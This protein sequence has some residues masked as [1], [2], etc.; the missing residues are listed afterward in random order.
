MDWIGLPLAFL[1]RVYRPLLM[2]ELLLRPLRN[3][4]KMVNASVMKDSVAA[5][6]VASLVEGKPLP[7]EEK[8]IEKHA[9]EASR[10]LFPPPTEEALFLLL[11]TPHS[12]NGGG[13]FP[14]KTSLSA[15]LSGRRER[16]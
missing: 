11:S 4:N 12:V 8:G 16:R 3:K 5:G 2:S 14:L 6:V 10:G 9:S 7:S 15:H 1:P 13:I